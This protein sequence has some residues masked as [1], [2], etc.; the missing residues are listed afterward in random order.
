V[1]SFSTDAVIVMIKQPTEEPAHHAGI[2][3]MAAHR[4]QVTLAGSGLL[5]TAS[6]RAWPL[7][8]SG[9]PRRFTVTRMW[10]ICWVVTGPSPR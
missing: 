4:W 2:P 9:T 10:M 7:W 3:R 8:H 5:V 1:P 6:G